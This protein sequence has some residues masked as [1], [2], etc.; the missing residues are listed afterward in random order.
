MAG[1]AHFKKFTQTGVSFS[2]MPR[3][4]GSSCETVWRL[5]AVVRE[6]GEEEYIKWPGHRLDPI[7]LGPLP[8]PHPTPRPSSRRAATAAEPEGRPNVPKCFFFLSF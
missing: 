3:K 6:Q 2:L 1:L 4:F 8:P 7:L 5:L